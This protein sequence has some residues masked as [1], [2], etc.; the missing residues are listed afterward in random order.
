MALLHKSG[1]LQDKEPKQLHPGWHYKKSVRSIVVPEGQIVTFYENQDQKGFKSR[2]FYEGEY[3]DVSWYG[4]KQE[5]GA[6]HIEKT[7]LRSQDMI[8]IEDDR[9]WK[10]DGKN[11]RFIKIWKLPVGDRRMGDDYPNDVIDR[12]I[13]PFGLEVTVFEDGSFKGGKLVFSGNNPEKPE[14]IFL[15]DFN[16]QNRVSSMQ[17]RSDNWILAGI[18]LEEETLSESKQEKIGATIELA[19]NSPHTSMAQKEISCEFEE[20]K[21][22]SW[23][24][25]VSVGITAGFEA[26][27]ETFKVK[28]ELEVT[29]SANFGETKSTSKTVSFDDIVS[30]QIEGYGKAKASMI[31]EYGAMEAIAVRKWRSK[32][33][34]TIIEDR[35]LI[36]FDVANRTRI[37]VH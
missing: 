33:N 1:W 17:I 22:E 11:H 19:N 3:L 37:E 28:G 12:I 35:G 7:E 20:G 14:V 27:P 21:E 5:P 15:K 31:I 26:G 25:G 2:L 24:A 30:V 9:Y 6:I 10:Q 4:V 13:I 18:A 36:K 8:Q 23:E 16:Y 32:R 34:N 29:A